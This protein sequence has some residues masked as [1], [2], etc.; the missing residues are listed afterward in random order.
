MKMENELKTPR[1]GKVTQIKVTPGQTVEKGDLL[2][3]IE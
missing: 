3:T 1:V 2:V